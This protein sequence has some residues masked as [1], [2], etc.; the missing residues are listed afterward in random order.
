MGVIYKNGRP[1]IGGSGGGSNL[2]A[3]GTTGQALVK[4]SNTDQDVEWAD[5]TGQIVQIDTLP[6]AS[7]S[8]VGEIYQYVGTTT[9][10]YTNGYFYRCAE[11]DGS[12]SW[13]P[14]EVQDGTESMEISQEDYDA[15]PTEQKMNG[16]VYYIND[17]DSFDLDKATY[18]FT[19]IGSII[20]VM[21]KTA[22]KDFLAC[23]GSVYNI[24]SY[25][26][27]AQFFKDQFD[28]ENYF[29]GDGVTTFAVPDLRGEFL[30][31]TGT[32]SHTDQGSGANVGV[33]QDSTEI[34]RMTGSGAANVGISYKNNTAGA[35]N[36]YNSDSEV[37]FSTKWRMLGGS[38]QTMS[39]S[40]VSFTVR[41]TN[42]SVLYCIAFKNIYITHTHIDERDKYSTTEKV[43]G[44]WIDGKPLYQKTF[45]CSAIGNNT[46]TTTQ[47]GLSDLDVV[48][49]FSVLMY[50]AGKT[51]F[52]KLPNPAATNS[53]YSVD[54]DIENGL[55]RIITHNG[56]YT[57]F[58]AHAIVQ[59][60]KTTD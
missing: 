18:G 59:Y 35:L 16:T 1:Y 58:K 24:S 60:T 33:H 51:S 55:L 17:G 37:A 19:P 13:D 6:A 32:N 7:A 20:S 41:P 3:G 48:V 23:D 5:I 2:P 12:Y 56:T 54:C 29:G 53:P 52:I 10:D 22:P 43:V 40:P 44:Q 47:L 15:L 9:S 45:E 27:L 50:N 25:P 26:E 34:P 42:T 46:T 28:A 49:D 57:T 39:D 30:R 21:S 36:I 11:H 14:C 8:N 38:E 4:H 31:G